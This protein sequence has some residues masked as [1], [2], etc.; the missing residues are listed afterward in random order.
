MA[1]ESDPK[2]IAEDPSWLDAVPD[3]TR[4]MFDL[5]AFER[6]DGGPA[7]VP[8]HVIAGTGAHPRLVAIAGIHGDEPDGMLALLEASRSLSPAGLRGRLVLVPIAHPAAFA[9]GQRRSP[10][11]G[12]DLNRIFPGTPEGMPTERLAHRLFEM[13]VR[14][15]D[16]LF[17]LHSWYA[18]GTVLPFVEVMSGESPVAAAGL[19]AARASSFDRIR[20]TDWPE[21][22]L[23]RVANEAGVPGMEAEIGGSGVASPEGQEQYRHHLGLLM[24]H[25]GMTDAAP[26]ASGKKS[27]L[28][29]GRHVRS[30]F[31]GVLSMRVA[32]GDSVGKNAVIAEVADLHGRPVGTVGSPVAG[33]VVSRRSY[34]SVAVG[35][36]LATVFSPAEHR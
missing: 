29:R 32:L 26:A 14:Q 16:F 11:D 30:P 27:R 10:L 22:L 24:S 36:I 6:A 8:V 21:G 18:T 20:L 4:A 19:A 2:R 9:A 28:F 34:G 13:V 31:A 15:A 5:V 23:V 12:L 3:R 25:L 1:I 35:D 17:T 33:I 7:T